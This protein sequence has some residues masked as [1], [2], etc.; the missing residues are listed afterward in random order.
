MIIQYSQSPLK[1]VDSILK[2]SLVRCSS[3]SVRTGMYFR[4]LM[5]RYLVHMC[6]HS[7][8]HAIQP[9]TH[10]SLAVGDM[11]HFHAHKEDSPDYNLLH[12]SQADMEYYSQ[13]HAI[14]AHIHIS[15]NKYGNSLDHTGLVD[16]QVWNTEFPANLLCRNNGHLC[17]NMLLHCNKNKSL[18][19]LHHRTLALPCNMITVATVLTLAL[20]TAGSTMRSL[21]A[22]FFTQ[23]SCPTWGTATRTRHMV[24]C[25]SILTA[26]PLGPE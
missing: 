3:V 23:G 19:S 18:Y 22:G 14:H 4:R 13:L 17:V 10:M 16:K 26:T 21:R 11:F 5:V 6:G 24:T 9:C 20:A 2:M 25:P 1:Y 12:I 15:L 8:D 7:E